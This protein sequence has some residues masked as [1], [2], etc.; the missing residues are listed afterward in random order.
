MRINVLISVLTS[1]TRAYHPDLAESIDTL[2]QAY[3]FL[4]DTIERVLFEHIP[5]IRLFFQVWFI[6]GET[7]INRLTLLNSFSPQVS[8]LCGAN[9]LDVTL[10]PRNTS[11]RVA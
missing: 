5:H 6:H 10:R 2:F 8:R 7:F 1:P 3:L 4:K 11:P 9:A